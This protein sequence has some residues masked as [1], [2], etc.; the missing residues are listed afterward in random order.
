MHIYGFGSVCRGDVSSGS[1]IDLLALVEGHD[2]RFD[3]NLYSIYSYKRIGEIWREGNPFAWHLW[4]E[5]RMLYS[6]NGVDHLKSLLEPAPYL[7]CVRDC[8]KF[9]T[10]FREAAA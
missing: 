5:S 10:L 8:Q 2:S 9:Y 6:S 3:P 7:H 4:L 1:D